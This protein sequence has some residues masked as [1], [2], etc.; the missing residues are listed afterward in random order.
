MIVVIHH[1]LYL[2][3]FN[4][5]LNNHNWHIFSSNGL[6]WWWVMKDLDLQLLQWVKILKNNF[7]LV[8][9]Y[10]LWFIL[11]IMDEIFDTTNGW[12]QV[13]KTMWMKAKNLCHDQIVKRYCIQKIEGMTKG[14]YVNSL[15]VRQILCLL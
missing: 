15:R 6:F 12:W 4:L 5:F 10:W 14:N 8:E 9:K 11:E 1:T 7:G 13:L 2:N 3:Y